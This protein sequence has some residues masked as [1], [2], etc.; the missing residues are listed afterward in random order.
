MNQKKA[1]AL[2]RAA[3]KLAAQ[4][5]DVHARDVHSTIVKQI[6][7]KHVVRI[8]PTLIAKARKFF[9]LKAPPIKTKVVERVAKEHRQLVM[10]AGPR[11]IL[12]RLKA[13][14]RRGEFDTTHS[15]FVNPL[16]GQ[17][18]VERSY[19][20]PYDTVRAMCYGTRATPGYKPAL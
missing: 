19:S 8:P 6:L 4:F 14:M 16:K 10:T 1:K 3:K 11:F 7:V 17:R 2:R 20:I 18:R 12:K 5:P 15:M 9:G 13:A